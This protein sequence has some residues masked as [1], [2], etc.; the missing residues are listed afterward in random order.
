MRYL[1]VYLETV[2]VFVVSI[3]VLLAANVACHVLKVYVDPEFVLVEKMT[4]TEFTV[5]MHES[6]VAE[7]VDVT[8]LQV[9]AESLVCVEFLLLQHAGLLLHANFAK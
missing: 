6:H 4:R 2:V 5:G 9:T 1:I 3:F 7:F 8:L